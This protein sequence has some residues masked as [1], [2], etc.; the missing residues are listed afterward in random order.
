[1]FDFTENNGLSSYNVQTI[2]QDKYGIIWAGTQDGLN[3]FNGK[4]FLIYN[5]V[6]SP[7]LS[8]NDIRFVTYDSI[9][10]YIWI[11]STNGGVDAIDPETETVVFKLGI[12]TIKKYLTDPSV[13]KIE[14]LGNDT[15]CL[16]TPS[17]LLFFNIR[18]KKVITGIPQ[19]F[20]GETSN[21]FVVGLLL[22]DHTLFTVTAGKGV[23][24]YNNKSLSLLQ[25]YKFP[26]TIAS[27]LIYKCYL[28]TLSK[29]IFI[30]SD[31]GLFIFSIGKRKYEQIKFKDTKLIIYCIA[32][33]N[34]ASFL[35]G[36]SKGIFSLSNDNSSL[37]KVNFVGEEDFGNWDSNV[38]NIYIGKEKGVWYAARKGLMLQTPHLSPFEKYSRN[39][40]SDLKINHLYFINFIDKSNVLA[41]GLNEI[42]KVNLDNG[43][44]RE[45]KPPGVY[46]Y[47]FED[48]LK[49]KFV[50]KDD[51]LFITRDFEN[52]SLKPAANV[53]PE[54][55]VI[56]KIKFNSHL[57][58]N[59]SIIVLAA[60]QGKGAFIWNRK[61]KQVYNVFNDSNKFESKYCNGLA[62]V[63]NNAFLIVTDS[64]LAFYDLFSNTAQKI[65]ILNEKN[66]EQRLFL[67]VA[68]INQEY[69]VASYGAGIFVLDSLFKQKRILS[70]KNGLSNAGIYKMIMDRENN[71]WVTTNYGLNRIDAS[72]YTI[73]SYFIK[74]G[75]HSNAFEEFSA[76]VSNGILIAGGPGGFTRI[77]PSR[78][79]Q[80]VEP[81]QCLF[82]YL[83]M[84][85]GTEEKKVHLFNNNLI[86]IP[87]N[88]YK[89]D[90]NVISVS[91][92]LSAELNYSYRIKELSDNWFSLGTRNTVSLLGLSQGIYHLQV[93]AA[94]E[95]GVWS[96]PTE[97]VLEFLPKWYQTWWF[98]A[99]VILTIASIIYTF[100]R[101][102]IAQ[103]K[104][105]HE[106]R[107]NIATDLH[108][109][110]GSTLNSVK[111]F[112]NLAISGV[113]QEESL[114][115]VKDNLNEATMGLRD[116]IWVLDD[117]LDTV[118][119]LVTRL[120]QFTLPVAAASNIQAEIKAESETNNLKLTKEEKRNLFLVCKE[121][122][123]NSIKYSGASLITVDIKPAGKKIQ[124]DITD[125]GKGFDET[126]VKKGYGLK[127]IQY[128]AGQVKYK[129]ILISSPGAGT[130][131]EIMPA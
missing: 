115:Q 68:K 98:N 16:N 15:L 124:I 108:D 37:N 23:S 64:E 28:D 72:S 42:Y 90:I 78:L 10:N 2:C 69:W 11:C 20:S 126:T 100:Y 123:N 39:I 86:L 120:K 61:S 14:L 103:I 76:N 59:D 93:R 5:K 66:E 44:I 32:R 110:L 128:R 94:N 107:K 62:K 26:G 99:F 102:R 105:Q 24:V 25:E 6:T 121:A 27:S 30:C 9:R 1:M 57:E 129:A 43:Q 56:E 73:K 46:Y 18:N 45:L 34:T 67:D 101:Y 8:G 58:L 81:K 131:V 116:M 63:S 22:T 82:E 80:H 77:D 54:L 4:N 92:D 53:Y 104:K 47:F 33:Q 118:D 122:I 31:N 19:P 52:L 51:G 60:E 91:Y 38:N 111:V 71:V 87:N 114:Q 119:E 49:R 84:N 89:V 13:Q 75:L 97:L 127:N 95:D 48:Q 83:T 17:G 35:M 85:N 106:I 55:S 36:T 109:D 7:Q 50:S 41:C 12:D 29:N 113:K 125:N 65:K 96:E 130:K 117:S 21:K 70:V 88:I 79:Y 40:S 3:R 74:D 112:T